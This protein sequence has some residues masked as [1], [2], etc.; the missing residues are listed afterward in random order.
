MAYITAEPDLDELDD[1]FKI[2][3][4]A[5]Q[6]KK[7]EVVARSALGGRQFDP[8]TGSYVIADKQKELDC[9]LPKHRR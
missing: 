1:W 6:R 4:A 3:A 5:S 2:G 8:E 7:P 9:R